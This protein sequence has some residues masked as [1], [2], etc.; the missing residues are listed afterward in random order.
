MLKKSSSL[1]LSLVPLFSPWVLCSPL[2]VLQVP[3]KASSWH[4][5]NTKN[6]HWRMGGDYRFKPTEELEQWDSYC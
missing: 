3:S 1:F 5:R 2:R 6:E 4:W